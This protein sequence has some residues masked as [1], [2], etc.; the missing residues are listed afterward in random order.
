MTTRIV[1]YYVY[2]SGLR[3]PYT[4]KPGLIDRMMQR[5]YGVRWERA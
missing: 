2:P 1:G 4:F 3:I 5:F